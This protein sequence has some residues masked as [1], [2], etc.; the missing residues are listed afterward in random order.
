MSEEVKGS[1]C[2][3]NNDQTKLN[4]GGNVGRTEEDK[5]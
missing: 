1:D 5:E 4:R 2:F 3:E